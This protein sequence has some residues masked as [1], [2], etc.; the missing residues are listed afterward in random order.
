MQNAL[1]IGKDGNKETVF[2]SKQIGA[3]VANLTW[4]KNF[5]SVVEESSDVEEAYNGRD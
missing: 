5:E 4:C 1:A 2:C 3:V